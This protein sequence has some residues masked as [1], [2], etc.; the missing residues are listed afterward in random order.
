M[1]IQFGRAMSAALTMS[2]VASSA[3]IRRSNVTSH[4]HATPSEEPPS[5]GSVASP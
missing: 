4:E 5:V 3:V 2:A 1:T